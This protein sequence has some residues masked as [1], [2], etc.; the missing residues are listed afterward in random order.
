MKKFLALLA[1]VIAIQAATALMSC[2]GGA[3]TGTGIMQE[4]CPVMGDPITNRNFF[5]DYQG[6][7]I[8]F[9][10]AACPEEF[11]KDPGKYLKKLDMT[12]LENAPVAR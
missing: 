12:K 8:Y 4:K 11:K 6:K 2:R 3:G 1:I 10:C 7:R 5:T 9:C